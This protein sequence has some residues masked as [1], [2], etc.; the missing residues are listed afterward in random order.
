MLPQAE[1]ISHAGHRVTPAERIDKYYSAAGR[2][3][4]V[5]Y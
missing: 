2:N 5:K 4:I 3:L 1:E